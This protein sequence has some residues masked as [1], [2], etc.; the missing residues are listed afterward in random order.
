[1]KSRILSLLAVSTVTL[2]GGSWLSGCSPNPAVLVEAPQSKET[3][4]IGGSAETYEALELLIEAYQAQDSD[5]D[6]KFFPPSQ[7]SGGLYGVTNHAMDIGGVSRVLKEEEEA[8]LTYVPLIEV[9]LVVAIHSS[10]TGI[11]DISADQIKAIYKGEITN[12]KAL[13]GPDADITLLDFTEDENEKQVLRQAY[14]G[15]NLKITSDAIVFAEDDELLDMAAITDFSIAAVPLEDEL[16]DLPLNVLRVDG[17][18]P[19]ANSIQSGEYPM[20]LSLGMVISEEA[21]PTAAAFAKFVTDEGQ[22]LLKT[23]AE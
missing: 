9:P 17:I 12:W 18:E 3:L 5:T 23:L 2:L 1:M 16:E 13:G 7:T 20:S 22:Q 8:N 4:R 10:V 21:S 15:D 14:L 11:T 6:V 19:S